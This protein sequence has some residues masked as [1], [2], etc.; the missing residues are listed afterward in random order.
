[1]YHMAQAEFQTNIAQ[2]QT[3][4]KEIVTE[5]LGVYHTLKIR[6]DRS[7]KEEETME[8]LLEIIYYC[9]LLLAYACQQNNNLAESEAFIKASKKLLKDKE[10]SIEMSH[11]QSGKNSYL[12]RIG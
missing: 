5:F 10:K 7:E 8:A 11:L 6:E 2:C 9:F 1:M 4:C 12:G 3:T